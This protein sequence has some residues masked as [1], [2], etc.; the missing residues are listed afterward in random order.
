MEPV[1][2]TVGLVASV[3]T[4]AQAVASGVSYV[5][6]L[7]DGGRNLAPT[8]VALRTEINGMSAVLAVITSEAQRPIF[9]SEVQDMWSMDKLKT[10]LIHAQGTVKRLGTIVDDVSSSRS[11]EST[12]KTANRSRRLKSYEQ[13]INTIR[14]RICVYI[15]LLQTPVNMSA[16]YS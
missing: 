8:I 14:L 16:R 6:S 12:W 3:V 10:L 5:R 9:F 15:Q 7:I 1:S 2:A 4:L 13:E 11:D